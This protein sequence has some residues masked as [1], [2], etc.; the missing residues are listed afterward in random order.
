MIP[1]QQGS[2]A[3]KNMTPNKLVLSLAGNDAIREKLASVSPGDEVEM[4]LK[5]QLDETTSEQASFSV[6]EANIMEESEGEDAAEGG[7]ES[8]MMKEGGDMGMEMGE[9]EAPAPK[10]KEGK[11]AMLLVFGK[12][13]KKSA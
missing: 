11:A 8:E 13:A 3:L 9:S 1:Y 4:E 10:S 5:V 12:G 2:N 6:V 7:E